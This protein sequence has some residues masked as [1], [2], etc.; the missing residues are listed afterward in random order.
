M[1]NFFL[2]LIFGSKIVAIG[3]AIVV[4]VYLCPTTSHACDKVDVWAN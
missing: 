1:R 2:I 4:N 3:P